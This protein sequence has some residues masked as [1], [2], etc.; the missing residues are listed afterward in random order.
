MPEHFIQA[1]TS[2]IK[3]YRAIDF[4][5]L[6]SGAISCFYSIQRSIITYPFGLI[7]VSLSIYLCYIT[8]IYGDVAINIFYFIMSCYGWYN[9]HKNKKSDTGKIKITYCTSTENMMYGLIALTS[10]LILYFSLKKYTDSDVYYIDSFTTALMINGMILMAYR[11]I[12]NWLYFIVADIISV[13]L[14]LY[15]GLYFSAILFVLL[16]F[17]A[18]VGFAK[19]KK[20]LLNNE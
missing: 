8:G 2:E 3:E 17:M 14:Y 20:E 15:K 13:P 7:S 9:W 18:I 16:T 6:I 1:L 11:K 10:Y 12:E 5:V 4:I 19:W